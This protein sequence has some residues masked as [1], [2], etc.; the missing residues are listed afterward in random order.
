MTTLTGK[1]G[2][3]SQN[4]EKQSSEVRGFEEFVAQIQGRFESVSKF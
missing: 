2:H 3:F 4:K 1:Q